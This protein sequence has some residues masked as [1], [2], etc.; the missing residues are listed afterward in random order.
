MS[1]A[2]WAL[3]LLPAVLAAAAIAMLRNSAL[4]PALAD[5]PNE[6]SLHERPTPRVGGIA[7]LGAALPVAALG[8]DFHVGVLLACAALLAV[9]S[10]M[11][12]VRS[13]PVQVRLPAH[14]A[15]AAVA[16]LAIAGPRVGHEGWNVLQLAVALV[17]IAW[18]S[19]LFNFMD[20]ADGLAGGMALIGFGALACAAER[21]GAIPLA[22]C[23]GAL[24]SASVGF[25]A[26]NFPPAR[27]FLGDAGSI[28]L[29]FLAATLGSLGTLEGA[30][31]WWFAPLVFAPFIADATVTLCRR[32]AAGEV[33]WRA[34]RR[35]AYQR[36]VL[37]GWS[38]R[39][40]ALAAY[41]LMSASALAA[42]A[43]LRA[44]AEFRYVIISV[45]VVVH[46]LIL[47]AVELRHPMHGAPAG[48]PG[49]GSSNNNKGNRRDGT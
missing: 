15:A 17:A 1:A 47:G 13:L 40:L 45:S 46:A 3:L 34:H 14:V 49:D 36:L 25:L 23:A 18:M 27:V 30:W 35:H 43:A 39:R 29:G 5:R 33:I 22:W 42:L 11:D 26:W 31:P 2:Q 8:A 20:G 21:A 7:L 16:L 9:V 44:E 37:G 10:A 19:N 28:P 38:K 48:T 24:A 4:A 12:D 6:R 32:L 41:A